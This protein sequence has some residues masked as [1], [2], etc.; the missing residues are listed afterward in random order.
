MITKRPR[1]CGTASA[2][3]QHST[4]PTSRKDYTLSKRPIWGRL[5][6]AQSLREVGLVLCR[7]W[8]DAEPQRQG[9]FVI[10]VYQK[11]SSVWTKLQELRKKGKKDPSSRCR[12]IW[13]IQCGYVAFLIGGRRLSRGYAPDWWPQTINRLCGW[14]LW[15]VLAYVNI[16]RHV[17]ISLIS[18]YYDKWKDLIL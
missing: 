9:R 14:S 6:K 11:W 10:S 7:G 13:R 2:Q 5:S 17:S 16:H 15:S 12:I 8:A 18:V 1:R 4:H 3:P